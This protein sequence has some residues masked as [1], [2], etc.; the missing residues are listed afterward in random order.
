MNN[1]LSVTST[2]SCLGL[3]VPWA[4]T[5]VRSANLVK[6]LLGSS[7]CTAV[8][9]DLRPI[10]TAKSICKSNDG[11]NA[12]WITRPRSPSNFDISGKQTTLLLRATYARGARPPKQ[13]PQH[14]GPKHYNRHWA[15]TQKQTPSDREF[16]KIFGPTV[17]RKT[18]NKLLQVLQAQRI[19]GTLDE[20][21][22]APGVSEPMIAN[23][24]N[25]LRANHPVDEDAAIMAR[26]EAEDQPAGL[27]KGKP[28]NPQ[29]APEGSILSGRSVL[30]SIK[31]QRKKD[32]AEAA[33]KQAE[34]PPGT[35]TSTTGIHI[36]PRRTQPAP[37]VQKYREKATLSTTAEPPQ[38]SHW[39][40]LWPST[41]V[42]LAIVALSV[43]LAQNYTPPK[44]SARLFPD[45]P[46]AAA[47]L[48][49]LVNM[50]FVVFLLW[51]VPPAWPALNRYFM[52]IPGAPRGFSMIGAVFSHKGL[53]HLVTNMGI[54]W[55]FGAKLHDDIGRGSFL[56]VYFASGALSSYFSL[57]ANVLARHLVTSSIG[58]SG[59]VLGV[60]AAWLSYHSDA[61]F[62]LIFLPADLLPPFSS[63]F[64][65]F[66][67]ILFE[68]VGI[69]MRFRHS[70]HLGHLGGLLSG[71]ACAH[72]LKDGARRRKEAKEG[73]RKKVGVGERVG[74]GG[75]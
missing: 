43:L 67:L 17:D 51:R 36:V 35:P 62:S 46:P 66:F 11:L 56:A 14:Q 52:M 25:W 16:A 37:W 27:E 57:T 7:R 58:A 1:V 44:R 29:Q 3:R 55:F 4:A 70:D 69:S 65:L 33:E 39:Q 31:A 47:T 54:L 32:E 24:L 38:L 48:L 22:T 73:R 71:I 61:K 5:N 6:S 74:E 53:W 28:Y 9:Q 8:W 75:L 34:S 42:T 20:E 2:A 72:V 40:R 41:L 45:L 68:V 15:P 63:N 13:V 21:I 18:G 49:A 23:A 50:N 64:L 12:G 60:I 10:S 30:E 59:A 19:A 26:L